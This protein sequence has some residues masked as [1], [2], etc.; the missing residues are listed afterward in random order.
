MAAIKK[1][2]KVGDYFE[3]GGK[4]YRITA[5]NTNGTYNSIREDKVEPAKKETTKKN[6][7]TKAS[8][9]VVSETE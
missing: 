9:V 8:V 5:V 4:S 7:K 3:D 6:G 1:G 2:L